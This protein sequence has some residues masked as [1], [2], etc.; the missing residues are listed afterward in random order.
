MSTEAASAPTIAAT[1]AAIVVVLTDVCDWQDSV[2]H[3]ARLAAAT[4]RRLRVVLADGGDLLNAAN[5]A[6]VRLMASGGLVSAFDPLEARRLVK[7]QIARL[8]RELQE[9]AARL[10]IEVE[11]IEATTTEDGLWVGTT[12]LTVFGR[13]RRGVIMV[14]HAGTVGTLEVAARLAAERRQEVRLLSAATA[15]PRGDPPAVRAMAD[16]FAGAARR[17][18]DAAPAG[19]RGHRR[20]ARDRPGMAGAAPLDAGGPSRAVAEA[21]GDE[22]RRHARHRPLS[23]AAGQAARRAS[24]S[25]AAKAG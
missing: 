6:C 3:A 24:A 19:R 23:G 14:V 21:A 5:L 22:G 20:R 11:L 18:R 1:G 7:A 12:A 9:L 8:R 25:R 16:R 4:G 2:R 15:D 10:A 17:C 13:R